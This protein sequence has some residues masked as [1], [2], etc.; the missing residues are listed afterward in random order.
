MPA[1]SWCAGTGQLPP[2]ISSGRNHAGK[3]V[4]F[5]PD[6]RHPDDA[7][8]GDG[9]RPVAWFQF[10]NRPEAYSFVKVMAE[11]GRDPV[12][13]AHQREWDSWEVRKT[14]FRLNLSR[15]GVFAHEVRPKP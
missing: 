7:T 1:H 4:E 9:L 5:D 6:W 15:I 14:C 11:M 13:G 10:W 12:T 8:A 2:I 3:W